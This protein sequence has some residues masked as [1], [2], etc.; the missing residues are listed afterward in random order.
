MEAFRDI[1]IEAIQGGSLFG[2]A[3]AFIFGLISFLSPC[4]LP[5]APPYLAYIGGT[6]LDQISGEKTEID[7]NAA[8][9]VFIAAIFF[10]L[11]LAVVFVGLGIG[12]ASAGNFLLDQKHNFALFSG[13][14]ICG[15]GMH[16]WGLRGAVLLTAVAFG[17]LTLWWLL[18]GQDLAERF[19]EAWLGLVLVGATAVALNLSG[20]DK[21]PLLNREAR[22]EGPV[23]TGS[24][25]SSFLIGMAFA[26]GWTPC[27]GPILATILAFAGQ[28]GDMVGGGVLLA[29]YALGL[30]M[31]FLIA[32]LFIGRF[33]RW[34]HGFR[35][36]LGLVER[37]MGAMLLAVGVMM[38]TGDFERLAYFLLET[39]PS[40][41]TIG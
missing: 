27:L 20:W 14:I 19:G 40:L 24:I 7:R 36:H 11:G 17:I 22:F 12:M 30:G 21:I 5:M 10:V 34:A 13:V 41:A 37:I 38:I 25:G 32:A 4:V 31:P 18:L 3:F 15:F 16:F 29:F 26:F 9:R 28:T 1:A 39:F 33:L 6:T 8:R 23:E 2:L 35:R